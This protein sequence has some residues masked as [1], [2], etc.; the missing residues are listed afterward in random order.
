MIEVEDLKNWRTLKKL[1]NSYDM[2][3]IGVVGSSIA[4]ES[5]NKLTQDQRDKLHWFCRGYLT[6]DHSYRHSVIE[7]R[8]ASFSA[9]KKGDARYI[10]I[11]EIYLRLISDD[12]EEILKELLEIWKSIK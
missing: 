3:D 12:K 5:K 8:P 1:L 10:S 2:I 11:S 7:L 6:F 9:L 4:R